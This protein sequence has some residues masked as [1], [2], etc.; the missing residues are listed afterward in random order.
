MKDVDDDLQP[1]VII[2]PPFGPEIA[3]AGV[4]KENPADALEVFHAVLDWDNQPEGC[5]VLVVDRLPVE[6]VGQQRLGVQ[7]AFH[8]DADVVTLVGRFQAD[9]FE[10]IVG[11]IGAGR[12]AAVG[13]EFVLH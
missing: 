4:G 5:A 10:Q 9:V 2:I 7:G 6:F 8:V 13:T 1:N 12:V 3:R 11:V